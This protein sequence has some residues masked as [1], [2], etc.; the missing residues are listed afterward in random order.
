MDWMRYLITG[1]ETCPTTGR[2]HYQC[3]C[4]TS[5]AISLAT[6]VKRLKPFHVEVSKDPPA[7]VEYCKKEGD[8]VETG[9]FPCPGK[10]TDLL[11]VRDRIMNGV[12]T[13]A[14][15]I[16]E[17][18]D[19]YHQYGRTLQAIEDQKN[20]R[21]KR[22]WMPDCYW[23][24]GP[25][26]VGKTRQ[27]HEK[28]SDLYVYPYEKAGWW[29]NYDGQE[30]VLFDDFRG[31]LPLNEVLRLCDRYDYSV[32]RRGRAPIPMLAKRIYFTSCKPLQD[33]YKDAGESLSQLER[34][35]I[36]KFI[37]GLEPPAEETE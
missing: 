3:H 15:I 32:A 2:K 25:T 27:V 22:C 6:A 11:E 23:L 5:N 21:K 7:S 9:D 4:Y 12:L 16:V 1:Y 14:T 17:S 18:P 34:R 26:G 36:S 30:A 24:W 31:Q 10:R 33:I 37:D 35:I 13:V 28:E 20:R 19:L 8:F 29:D